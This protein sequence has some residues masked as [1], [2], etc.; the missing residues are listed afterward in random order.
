MIFKL[1]L[2]QQ[3]ELKSMPETGMGYQLIQARFKGEYN[4]RELIVLNEELFFEG[5]F[6][7]K[8]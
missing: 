7:T 8:N 2:K 4:L 3:D 5:T 1:F 6:Q